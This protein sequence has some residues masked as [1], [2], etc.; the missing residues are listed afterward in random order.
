MVVVII[1]PYFETPTTRLFHGTTSPSINAAVSNEWLLLADYWSDCDV[2]N[3]NVSKEPTSY[4]SWIKHFITHVGLLRP[5]KRGRNTSNQRSFP[6]IL[7]IESTLTSQLNMWW[8]GTSW[9]NS[10]KLP[11][12]CGEDSHDVSIKFQSAHETTNSESIFYLLL[13][14]LFF[15]KLS[16]LDVAAHIKG[17]CCVSEGDLWQEMELCV[18]TRRCDDLKV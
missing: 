3:H 6:L 9:G 13:F 5:R 2:T 14:V 18:R 7:A 16:L 10:L 12:R 15:F 8:L 11:S 17:K 4:H 1:C